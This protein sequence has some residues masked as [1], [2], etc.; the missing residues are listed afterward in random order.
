MNDKALRDEIAE[1]RAQNAALEAR[2]A[3][4]EAPPPRRNENVQLGL[5]PPLSPSTYAAIDRACV[6]R[7]MTREMEERVGTKMVQEIVRTTKR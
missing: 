7:A 5:E 2:L 3:K 6:P 4:L 1:L